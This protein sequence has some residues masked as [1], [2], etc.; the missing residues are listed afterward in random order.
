M[1]GLGESSADRNRLEEA[2]KEAIHSPLLGEVDAS[3]A[4]GAL[5]RVV[6]GPDLSISE[7]E[8]AAEIITSSIN[9]NARVIWGCTID[10]A[11]E[12]HVQVLLVLTGVRSRHMMG[13]GADV[14]VVSGRA[15]TLGIDSV[16]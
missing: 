8:R 13:K 1:I 3:K 10:P 5:I 6:G 15:E 7:A 11:M 12:G 14:G 9:P 16:R 2:V 4:K